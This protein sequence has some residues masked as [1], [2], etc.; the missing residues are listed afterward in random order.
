MIQTGLDRL[1]FEEAR[2]VRG[3]RVALLPERGQFVE[4]FEFPLR[5]MPI[6]FGDEQGDGKIRALGMPGAQPRIGID[7]DVHGPRVGTIKDR[8]VLAG[9]AAAEFGIVAR[10]GD[11]DAWIAVGADVEG[12]PPHQLSLATDDRRIGG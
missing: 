2:L 3:R 4:G 9:H 1:G 5:V 7:V 12:P 6:G 11:R 8:Q 10:D